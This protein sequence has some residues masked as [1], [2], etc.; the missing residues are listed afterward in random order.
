MASPFELTT[1]GSVALIDGE[2]GETWTRARLAKAVGH[3][4][5]GLRSPRKELVFCACERDVGSAIGYLAAVAAGHAVV[6][7]DRD[8]HEQLAAALLE[9]YRPRW[10]L[11]AQGAQVSVTERAARSS[12]TEIDEELAVLLSTSGTTGSPRLVR[13]ARRNLDANAASIVEYLGIDSGERAIASLPIHYS[14]GLSVV[15]SHLAAGASSPGRASSA[16]R[17]GSRRAATRAPRLPACRIPT[18][19]SNGPGSCVRVHLA[20]CTP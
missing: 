11:M 4:A 5:H 7:T 20:R 14:Y 8:V 18:R 16:R 12:A 9:R 15:N 19:C 17:S 6:L 2:T 3:I 10:V 13:L 1:D